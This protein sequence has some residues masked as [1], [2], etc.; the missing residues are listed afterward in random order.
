MILMWPRFE[1][2]LCTYYVLIIDIQGV[3][4]VENIIC[5]KKG[6]LYSSSLDPGVT[7]RVTRCDKPA[8]HAYKILH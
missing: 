4:F 6:K 8:G 3:Q 7:Q 5:E 2:S 1:E